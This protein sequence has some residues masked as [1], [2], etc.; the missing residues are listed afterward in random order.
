MIMEIVVEK[1]RKREVVAG[2]PMRWES[3]LGYSI[4]HWKPLWVLGIP[5]FDRPT[6]HE[7]MIHSPR[8]SHLPIVIFER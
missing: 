1:D 5:F 6:V 2:F 3:G 4:K 7:T 8:S